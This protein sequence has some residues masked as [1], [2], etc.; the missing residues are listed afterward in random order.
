[1]RRTGG[2][3][4][5]GVIFGAKGPIAVTNDLVIDE[6][7]DPE[8]VATNVLAVDRTGCCDVQFDSGA[9]NTIIEYLRCYERGVRSCGPVRSNIPGHGR[10]LA[11][12]AGRCGRQSDGRDGRKSSSS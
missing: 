2:L 9:R 10:Q 1:M 3:P 12:F 8:E 7:V 11:D 5:E 4:D 6:F